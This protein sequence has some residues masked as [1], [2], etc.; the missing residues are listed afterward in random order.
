[1]NGVPGSQVN[2]GTGSDNGGGGG[3]AGYIRIN[4]TTGASGFTGSASPGLTSTCGTQG[5]LTH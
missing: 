1:V 5:T 2:T 4:T 3:A